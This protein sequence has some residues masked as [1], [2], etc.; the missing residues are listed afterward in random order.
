MTESLLPPDEIVSETL[1]V[2]AVDSHCAA[3]RRTQNIEHGSLGVGALLGERPEYRV[4]DDKRSQR[5]GDAKARPSQFGLVRGPFFS[6]F[7]GSFCPAS[8]YG[9]RPEGDIVLHEEDRLPGSAPVPDWAR[10]SR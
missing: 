5:N 3:I 6:H 2:E 8:I 9:F 10:A 4:Q 1:P 7:R